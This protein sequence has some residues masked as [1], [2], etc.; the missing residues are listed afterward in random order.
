MVPFVTEPLVSLT[1]SS[2]APALI[3]FPGVVTPLTMVAAV[4]VP[5]LTIVSLPEP[6]A[7]PVA[8]AV[9]S[10]EPRLL[11]ASTLTLIVPLLMTVL[12][13]EPVWMP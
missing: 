13:P 11:L 12:L 9:I 7:M 10:P 5:S 6:V 8:P 2:P 3:A 4:I 1:T